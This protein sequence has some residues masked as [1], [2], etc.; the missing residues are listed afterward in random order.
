[1]RFQGALCPI[2]RGVV[3][4]HTVA[5]VQVTTIVFALSENAMN[6]VSDLCSYR[7]LL[8]EY[9]FMLSPTIHE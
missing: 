4:V 8:C 2:D 6:R 1:M 9:A 7:I 3:L 5:D